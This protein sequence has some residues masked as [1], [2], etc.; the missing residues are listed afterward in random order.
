MKAVSCTTGLV[1]ASE[2]RSLGQRV[3]LRLSVKCR[4]ADA[5]AATAVAAAGPPQPLVCA[6]EV[7]PSTAPAAIL[8]L[9]DGQPLPQR[10]LVRPL[11]PSP[12]KKP[13]PACS[14]LRFLC[15]STPTKHTCCAPAVAFRGGAIYLLSPGV[16]LVSSGAGWQ[17]PPDPVDFSGR[18]VGLCCME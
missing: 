3:P 14:A 1:G 5:D 12:R 6:L 9:H 11:L 4:P 18:L 7:E 17:V 13:T 10:E 2:G 8:L 15:L 16:L